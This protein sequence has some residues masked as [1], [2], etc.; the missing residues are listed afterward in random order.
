MFCINQSALAGSH[1]GAVPA[2]PTSISHAREP[3]TPLDTLTV[4]FSNSKCICQNSIMYLSKF[5]NIFVKILQ[6]ICPNS[7]MYLSKL[8]LQLKRC[9]RATPTQGNANLSWNINQ[10][11]HLAFNWQK[12]TWWI[13]ADNNRIVLRLKYGQI[14][15]KHFLF[16]TCWCV[17]S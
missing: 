10:N 16:M 15:R 7:T 11:L 17:C 6:C 13:K 9:Q 14:K 3:K 2:V 12:T 5:Y 8:S 1:W 4:V